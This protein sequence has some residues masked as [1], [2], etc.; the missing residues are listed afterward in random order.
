MEL[1]PYDGWCSGKTT[2]CYLLIVSRAHVNA[3]TWR[4]HG[5]RYSFI[6][7]V[8]FVPGW[9]SQHWTH[10]RWHTRG[11]HWRGF[12]HPVHPS[13]LHAGTGWKNRRGLSTT[14]TNTCTHRAW[15]WLRCAILPF[16]F[17]VRSICSSCT[18]KP[19]LSSLYSLTTNLSRLQKAKHWN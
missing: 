11:M 9:V 13:L 1:R 14:C 10:T 2:L 4:L 3:H 19:L 12:G 5:C 8:L 17:S 16:C 6:S 18:K 7:S 15:R